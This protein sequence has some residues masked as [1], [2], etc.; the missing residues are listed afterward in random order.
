MRGW[1]GSGVDGTLIPGFLGQK[2]KLYQRSELTLHCVFID[3]VLFA[4]LLL[5][6]LSQRF[7]GSY[8]D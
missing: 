3:L 8:C 5:A 6:H 2:H 7:K 1:M 4:F